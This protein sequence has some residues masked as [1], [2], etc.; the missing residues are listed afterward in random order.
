MI[1]SAA[2]DRN[3][4]TFHSTLSTTVSVAE[5]T[6]TK[7]RRNQLRARGCPSGWIDINDASWDTCELR[8]AQKMSGWPD[9]Q[10]LDK[11][12]PVGD[13]LPR[14]IRK[15]R[16]HQAEVIQIFLLNIL[17]SVNRSASLSTCRVFQV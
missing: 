7:S 14:I 9:P 3:P 4:A 16:R 8:I 12:V 10:R 11:G 15:V 2:R 5:I 17:A 13:I 6:G 1:A